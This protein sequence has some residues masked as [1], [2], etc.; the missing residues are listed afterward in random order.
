MP[1]GVLAFFFLVF[2]FSSPGA[3][4]S[5]ETGGPESR[6][7]SGPRP[8]AGPSKVSIRPKHA[9]EAGG[10]GLQ[11]DVSLIDTPTTSVLD[12]HG[13]ATTARFF[14]SGGVLEHVSFGVFHRLNIGASLNVDRL[15]GSDSST[16]VRAPN[17]QAKYRFFDGDGWIPSAAV[18]FDGQGYLYD[19]TAKRYNHRHRGFFLVATQELFIPGLQAH[20]SVNISDFDSNSIYGAIPLSLNFRDWVCLMFEWDSVSDWSHSRINSGLRVYVTP[21]FHLDFGVR[22]I[23]QGGRFDDG[24]PRGP[25]RVAQIRYSGNF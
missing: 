22:G 5:A 21:G 16:R 6:R 2:L 13:Y 11:P 23:G 8:E 10:R 1:R 7:D 4:A 25:E 12:Y 20:P 18:G 17:V 19:G 14:S 9:A 24:A 15:I 3:V